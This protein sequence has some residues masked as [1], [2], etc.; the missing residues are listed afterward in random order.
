MFRIQMLPVRHGDC[1]LVEY[2]D[3]AAPHRVLIDAGP[4]YAFDDV[5]G[6]IDELATSG[7]TFELFVITH[8]D[9]DHIDGAIKL[10]GA[11]PEDI[12]F[13]DV[14]F[15]SW[16]H[17]R[18]ERYLSSNAGDRLGPVH[19]EMLSALIEKHK[20]PWNEAFG[21]GPVST[22][23][24]GTLL[25]KELPGQLKLTLLSPRPEELLA[26]ETPWA[27]E[28]RKKGFEPGS[29]E[30]ALAYLRRQA[31]YRPPRDRLGDEKPDIRRLAEKPF[32]EHETPTNA[33]SIAFLAE[34]QGTTCLF[35]G[36]AQPSVLEKTLKALPTYQLGRKLKVDALKVSHHG[37]RGNTSH[38]LLRMMECSHFLISSDGSGNA[39]H[40]HPETIARLIQESPAGTQLWFNYRSDETKIWDDEF[41][42]KRYKYEAHYPQDRDD[43]LV[44]ALSEE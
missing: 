10:L 12:R 7:L 16:L 9:T 13:R 22:G 42:K 36:D 11:R 14:W 28:V 17:L 31:N 4:Y 37:S 6:R 38:D 40:P 39:N 27:A 3:A 20:L 32:S 33:S 35:A 41:L 5:A 34:Y 30:G 15:N 1:L 24:T 19:G 44:V 8:V 43:G 18:P 2:G 21:G 25:V 26:L 23:K 29:R